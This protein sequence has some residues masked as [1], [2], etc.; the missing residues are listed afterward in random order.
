[1]LV[2]TELFN[3]AVN[4]FGAKK[5][6][7]CRRVLI[8]TEL[9]VNGASVGSSTS[10]LYLK[11][12]IGIYLGSLINRSNYFVKIVSGSASNTKLDWFIF[13]THYSCGTVPCNDD[14]N[15]PEQAI[16][17]RTIKGHKRT[18]SSL[19]SKVI[20]ILTNNSFARVF[21][22]WSRFFIEEKSVN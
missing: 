5:S 8:V 7:H 6:A 11:I 18:K 17:E 3:I 15:N 9:T 16:A 21:L 10:A 13:F 1:M 19:K 14:V 4:Y 20:D 2:V 12:F 22:E